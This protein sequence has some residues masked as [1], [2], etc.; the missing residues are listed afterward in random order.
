MS[1]LSS[2]RGGVAGLRAAM[3]DIRKK[4]QKDCVFIVHFWAAWCEPCAHMDTVLESLATASSSAGLHLV[5]LRCE[6][7]EE[8][9][10]SEAYNVEA[11]P[12]FVALT[13]KGTTDDELVEEIGRVEGASPHELGQLVDRIATREEYR[14]PAAKED[15]ASGQQDLHSR[16]EAL[17]KKERVMLFMK[18]KPSEPRCG[19]SRKV[20]DALVSCYGADS[21]AAQSSVDEL[22]G[23]FDILGDQEIRQGLKEFS[24]WPTFPQL[25]VDGELIGGC[26]I[27]LEMHEAGELKEL[28]IASL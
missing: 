8:G 16:L 21:A 19:F 28:I 4:S 17:V 27:V 12:T 23:N 9:E 18:G 11:V 22:F 7:E 14:R 5:G 13:L 25:Y 3:H 15:V 6:A 20:A 2:V 24:K 26:D 1:T 10:V